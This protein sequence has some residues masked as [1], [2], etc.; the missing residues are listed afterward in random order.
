MPSKVLLTYPLPCETGDQDKLNYDFIESPVERLHELTQAQRKEI[1]GV[2]C[3]LSERISKDVLDALP[4][5]KVIANYAVGLDNIDV[6]ECTKRKIMVCHTP[7]VLTQAS[8][9]HAFSL[10]LNGIR[11]VDESARSARRGEWKGWGPEIFLGPSPQDLTLG[12]VGAG[13]IG[14]ALAELAKKAFSMN[15]VYNSRHTKPA[16]EKSYNAKALS[17]DE[18]LK[19]SDIVS[20]HTPLTS[21]TRGLI[22]KEKLLM[23]KDK[24]ILINTSRGEVINQEDLCE[25]LRNDHLA[26][27]GLDVTTPEPLP[28]EHELYQFERV[29]ITAHIASAETSTRLDMSWLCFQNVEEALSGGRPPTL[30]NTELLE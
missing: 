3:L 28:Q 17:L 21:E 30:F 29:T 4:N 9:N 12:I 14:Q 26:H 23:M 7:D 8:A 25:V 15:I 18:L 5:L 27:V 11:R 2:M 13:R 20:L 10:M 19:T 1:E 22:N 6:D 16:F 24:A